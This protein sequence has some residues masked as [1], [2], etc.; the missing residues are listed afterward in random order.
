MKTG[1]V[2]ASWIFTYFDFFTYTR[3]LYENNEYSEFA[4]PALSMVHSYYIPTE[5]ENPEII[6]TARNPYDR[7]LSRFL[8]T[9]TK[10][11]LPTVEDFDLHI[12]KSIENNNPMY[13]MPDHIKP[14]YVIHLENLYEDYMK[15][16]FVVDS[17]LNSSG[18]LKEVIYK[19]INETR[20]KV[21]KN[22]FL[23][24]KNK[25]LI[26]NLMKNQFDL[27]GYEK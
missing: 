10:N 13:V 6:I 14:T 24:D 7:V 22:K 25:E 17:K 11:E 23:T 19:K 12:T 3:N 18:I 21:D 4:N 27:F 1:S 5:V 9:W 16:P 26:Y 15:I 2:T 20:F 8:F